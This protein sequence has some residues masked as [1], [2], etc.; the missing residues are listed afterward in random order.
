MTQKPLPQARVFKAIDLY[1]RFRAGAEKSPKK[2]LH[3]KLL[4]SRLVISRGPNLDKLKKRKV[5]SVAPFDQTC[6]VFWTDCK[7]KGHNMM[8]TAGWQL[9]AI[10]W[11]DVAQELT[12]FQMQKSGQISLVPKSMTDQLHVGLQ[13]YLAVI[14]SGL[15]QGS[16]QNPTKAFWGK[17]QHCF[18][19]DIGEVPPEYYVTGSYSNDYSNGAET[20]G[21]RAYNPDVR[22]SLRALIKRSKKPLTTKKR[23]WFEEW[24]YTLFEEDEMLDDRTA[25]FLLSR[26]HRDKVGGEW[27]ACKIYRGRSWVYGE[28]SNSKLPH[29][30]S[31][32]ISEL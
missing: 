4:D 30:P 8:E 11:D 23:E 16:N 19:K 29:V 18:T 6:V 3:R 1:K 13:H 25:R 10:L 32:R 26:G 2:P 12:L 27:L 28:M 24:G 17:Q 9:A 7:Y 22:A 14:W 15:P 5:L 21:E 31:T 20:T